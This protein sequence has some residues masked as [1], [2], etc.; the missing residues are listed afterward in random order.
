MC[1]GA[2]L[3]YGIPRVVIGENITFHGEE[4]LLR[5]RGVLIEMV[6]ACHIPSMRQRNQRIRASFFSLISIS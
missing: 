6:P 2:I 5:G 1:S 3:L 4:E